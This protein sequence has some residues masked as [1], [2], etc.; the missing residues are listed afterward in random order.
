MAIP[1][2]LSGF[3]VKRWPY[4]IIF[5][6]LAVR[7]LIENVAPRQPDPG[8]GH[9]FPATMLNH[10]IHD[11]IYLTSFEWP[12]YQASFVLMCAGVFIVIVQGLT[13]DRNRPSSP[14]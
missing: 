11:I 5:L 1:R 2:G 6:G 3:I 13:R 14:V 9:V 10:R 7:S 12:I 4:A 8:S